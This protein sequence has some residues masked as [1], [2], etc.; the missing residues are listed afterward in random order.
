MFLV[1]RPRL[2]TG[3]PD[4]IALLSL[5]PPSNRLY[6]VS[7]ILLLTPLTS[8]P[9]L[10][11]ALLLSYLRP[12]SLSLLTWTTAQTPHWSPFLQPHLIKPTLLIISRENFLMCMSTTVSLFYSLLISSERMSILF[13]I[14][15][16]KAQ[17]FGIVFIL[18]PLPVRMATSPM[19]HDSH[20]SPKLHHFLWTSQPCSCFWAFL[21]M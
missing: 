3:E 15:L 8:D 11:C 19:I 9:L 18:W 14:H 6:Q 4:Q 10:P 12:L 16:I 13:I 21:C 2:E 5:S 20:S 1:L 7:P 17:L